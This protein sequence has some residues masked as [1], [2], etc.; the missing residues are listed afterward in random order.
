MAFGFLSRFTALGC[1][2]GAMLVFS[3]DVALRGSRS[4]VVIVLG[5]PQSAGDIE[6]DVRARYA[7]P[8]SEDQET[9]VRR[10]VAAEAEVAWSASQE[11]LLSR[12]RLMGA[13][14]IRRFR[15]MNA[16]SATVPESALE[17]LRRDPLVKRVVPEQRLAPKLDVSGP[18]MG[19]PAFSDVGLTGAGQSILM[20]DSGVDV[21][22]PAF[23]GA[24]IV[25]APDL[26]NQPNYWGACQGLGAAG[27][28]CSQMG[29]GTAVAGILVS[30]GAPGF[31]RHLGVARRATVYSVRAVEY[32]DEGNL[33]LSTA[34]ILAAIDW[35][36]A[37]TPASIINISYA[38]TWYSQEF[39]DTLDEIQVMHNVVI[40][41]PATAITGYCTSGPPMP[42]MSQNGIGVGALDDRNTISTADDGLSPQNAAGPGPNGAYK[43]DV[44]APG[45]G[46]TAPSNYWDMNGQTFRVSPTSCHASLATA[47]VS[48]AL[49]LIRQS[50][51]TDMVAAKAVLINS[52]EDAGWSPTRGWGAVNLRNAKT[53]G[54]LL[55]GKLFD[56]QPALFAGPVASGP[57]RMTAAIRQMP[58]GAPAV[59]RVYN[60]ANASVVADQQTTGVVR[61]FSLPSGNYVVSLRQEGMSYGFAVAMSRE[62]FR[63]MTPP[64]VGI[65]CSGPRQV[66]VGALMTFTCTA[67]NSG[68]LEAHGVK[69]VAGVP[70]TTCE[71]DFGVVNGRGTRTQQCSVRATG[72]GTFPMTAML[73]QYFAYNSWDVLDPPAGADFG[74]VTVSGR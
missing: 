4:R 45:V 2:F 6:A 3:Q 59:F 27:D 67:R 68:D 15:S 33:F 74:T 57:V 61:K 53:R 28:D 58:G 29:H 1:I 8:L 66:A 9:A 44:L 50:G 14:D 5:C 47:H 22:N 16:M 32:T 49:A 7:V 63:Q 40:V 19:V 73:N 11:A 39:I 71:I 37:N 21:R 46:I 34:N 18:T 13:T 36:L 20:I 69:A 35:G 24:N 55:T 17:A 70:A 62:G 25:L 48:G 72:A 43:P 31:S 30:Q 64:L 60:R 23:A 26:W 41:S 10:A 54:S 52:T 12:L 56:R 65:A 42:L 38:D 51:V